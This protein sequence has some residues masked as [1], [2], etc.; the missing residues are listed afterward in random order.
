MPAMVGAFRKLIGAEFE[1][2]YFLDIMQGV[3]PVRRLY[4][5]PFENYTA[6]TRLAL[7]PYIDELPTEKNGPTFDRLVE[8]AGK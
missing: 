7:P 8:L 3:R 4:T 5:Q 2:T 1:E 6:K